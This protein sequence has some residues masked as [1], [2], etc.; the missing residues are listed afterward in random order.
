MPK[1]LVAGIVGIGLLAGCASDGG[2]GMEGSPLWKMRVSD[3]KVKAHY[4]TVEK[5]EAFFREVMINGEV[6]ASKDAPFG[7]QENTVKY[8][9]VLYVCTN[10]YK[11]CENI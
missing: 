4:T 1:A 6:L 5:K 8:K 11:R 2:P 10:D 7:V 3:E 9:G